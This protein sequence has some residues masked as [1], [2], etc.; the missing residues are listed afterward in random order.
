MI[1]S[2]VADRYAKALLLFSQHS[3]QVDLVLKDLLYI[4]DVLNNSQEFYLFTVNPIIRPFKKIAIFNELFKNKISDITFGFLIFLIKKNRESVLKTL[5]YCFIE[6][7]NELMGRI[8]V[9]ITSANDLNEQL[10]VAICDKLQKWTGKEI[11]PRFFIDKSIIGG[12]QVKFG[13][14]FYDASVK[15]QLNKLY[16]EISN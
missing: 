5:I 11:L 16:T 7:Y 8:H 2:K 4:Q 14:Y 9:D 12:F 3:N 1:D 6:Q 10:K 15:K 13:D